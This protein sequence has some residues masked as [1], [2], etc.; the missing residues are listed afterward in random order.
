MGNDGSWEY[1]LIICEKNIETS[2]ARRESA[3]LSA[4]QVSISLSPPTLRMSYNF[5]E[6]RWR[7]FHRVLPISNKFAGSGIRI[8]EK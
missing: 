3:V 8:S 1:S 5:P 2:W 6:T 4:S 7:A